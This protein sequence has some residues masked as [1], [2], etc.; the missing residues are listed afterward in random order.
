M[1]KQKNSQ[2]KYECTTTHADIN[3][4]IDKVIAGIKRKWKP[5]HVSKKITHEE[6]R[7][8]KRNHTK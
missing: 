7:N 8:C 6:R 2:A 3:G 5:A 4:T 1:A